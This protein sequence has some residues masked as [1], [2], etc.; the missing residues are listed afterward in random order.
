MDDE[1]HTPIMESYRKAPDMDLPIGKHFVKRVKCRR[2]L[3]DTEDLITE[4]SMVMQM[5]QHLGKI[6]GLG[7][8]LVKFKKKLA[9]A[10]TWKYTKEFFCGTIEDPKDENKSVGVEPNYQANL[11]MQAEQKF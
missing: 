9:A 5:A 7:G 3:A 6:A 11:V 4:T 1:V 2:L 10:R 8:K